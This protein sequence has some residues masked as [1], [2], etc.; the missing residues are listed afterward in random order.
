MFK[1]KIPKNKE[2][3]HTCDNGFCV[4]PD[5][6]FL[7]THKENMEDRDRKGRANNLIGENHPSVKLTKEQVLEIRMKRQIWRHI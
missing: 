1:G 4:N 2:V 7:G 5:H 3:C 6:L